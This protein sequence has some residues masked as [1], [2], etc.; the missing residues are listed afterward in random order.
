MTRSDSPG[1]LASAIFLAGVAAVSALLVLPLPDYTGITGG[2]LRHQDLLLAL[3]LLVLLV[4]GPLAVVGVA[5]TFT[6][7][8]WPRALTRRPYYVVLFL[9]LVANVVLVVT[10]GWHHAFTDCRLCEGPGLWPKTTLLASVFIVI[11]PP[12]FRSLRDRR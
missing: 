12:V 10:G 5:V 1:C 11:A 7:L 4:A 8:R 9:I 3:A 6:Y 2:E